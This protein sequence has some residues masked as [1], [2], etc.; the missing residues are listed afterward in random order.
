MSLQQMCVGTNG[1]EFQGR[2]LI[3]LIIHIDATYISDISTCALRAL[4]KHQA[5]VFVVE[6]PGVL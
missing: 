6:T 3:P 4:I 1:Q 2:I 5:L